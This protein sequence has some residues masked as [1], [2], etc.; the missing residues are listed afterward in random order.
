MPRPGLY[1][2]PDNRAADGKA[3]G[4]V[5]TDSPKP[6]GSGAAV[7]GPSAAMGSTIKRNGILGTVYLIHLGW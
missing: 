3:K 5:V 4:R 1:A 7:I 2:N 6:S